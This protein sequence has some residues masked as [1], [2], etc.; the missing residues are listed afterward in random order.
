MQQARRT[1]LTI[2]ALCAAT[3]V[4]A[5]PAMAGGPA[6]LPHQGAVVR[7]N[8][9]A[10]ELDSLSESA[11]EIYELAM[12]G[13][14]ERVP[15]K[16]ESMKKSAAA[17]PNLQDETN[18]ILFPRLRHTLVELEQAVIAK[19][20]HTTMLYANRITL[21]AANVSIPMKVTIPTE[22]SL[23]DYN[24]RELG[25]WSDLKKTEKLSNIVMRMHLAWQALMPKLVEHNGTKELKRFSEIMRRL[26][27]ARTPEEYGKLS[28]Q[29]AP[30]MEGIRTLFQKAAK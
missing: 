5:A 26:E 14:M 29:V 15:R 1:V 7:A 12:A 19:D 2:A 17:L 6:P 18:N 8:P 23:L 4:S 20:R 27:L 11:D 21:I 10:A 22:V 30:E 3:L 9:L 16:L 25:I 13:K 24:G 28:R